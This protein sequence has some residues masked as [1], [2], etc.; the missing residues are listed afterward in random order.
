MC[1]D[2]Q[3]RDVAPSASLFLALWAGLR[4]YS[5]HHETTGHRLFR[6]IRV[7][8]KLL[9][10]LAAA[11]LTCAAFAADALSKAAPPAPSEK[12]PSPTTNQTSTARRIVKA[13]KVDELVPTINKA[14][15]TKRNFEQGKRLFT[16]LSCTVCHHFGQEG[17]GVGPD[18]TGASGTFSVHDLLENIIEP[19]KEISSLYVTTNVRKKDG[20][21]VTGWVPEETETT[22]SMIEDMFSAGKLTVIKKSDI[23]SM[24]TS[25][26]SLM[27][28]DLLNTLKEDEIADLV[29][30]LL[31]TGDPTHRYFK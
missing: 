22:V 28:A 31:S 25:K 16:E 26:V 17:G 15:K 29:A 14:L 1:P 27:P 4:E 24:Q 18:L 7:N 21:V 9:F 30:F 13:W 6:L 3:L 12:Q 19:S 20:E 8:S 2:A 23:E 11:T 5:Q 10:I